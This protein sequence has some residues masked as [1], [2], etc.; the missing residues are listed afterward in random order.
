MQT[1]KLETWIGITLLVVVVVAFIFEIIVKLPKQSAVTSQA[2]V[3]PT[4][5][6]DLFSSSNPINKSVSQLNIPANLPVT[7]NPPD[8]GRDNVFK[9]F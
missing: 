6:R 1:S 7:V 8:V 4:I 2:Q 5:P 3:V 9:S